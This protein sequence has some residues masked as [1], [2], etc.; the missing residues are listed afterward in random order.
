MRVK[1]N[2]MKLPGVPQSQCEPS[3]HPCQK[4][5]FSIQSSIIVT[6]QIGNNRV[7]KIVKIC[8]IQ[9]FYVKY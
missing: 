1:K 9:T 5:T 6:L 3:T 2:V 8:N 4:K 7:I